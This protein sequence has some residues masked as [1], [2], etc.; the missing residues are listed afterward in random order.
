MSKSNMKLITETIEQVKPIVEETKTG[1]KKYYIEGIFLQANKQNR[2]G[3]IYPTAIME[4][5][6]ERYVTDKVKSNRALGELGHPEGPNINLHRVSH[7]IVE[8]RQE[9]DNFI[10]KAE[11]L[12]TPYGKIVK[13]LID[14]GVSLGVSSRGMGS[15]K[16][17]NGINEVQ[18]DFKLATAADIVA[19]P[20][21][22]QAFVNGIM[23]GVEW[24]LDEEG[25]YISIDDVQEQI[26]A[27]E[28]EALKLVEEFLSKL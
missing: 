28:K 23:E 3:R 6:V 17:V 12:D 10:G 27:K 26:N 4:R 16:V 11:I 7:K 8:I 19:D 15:V 9:G 1:G 13:N 22:P 21:A 2:N 20:S 18:Q 14:S 25:H 5:E 24:V